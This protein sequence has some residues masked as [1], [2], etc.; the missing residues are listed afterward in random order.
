MLFL[1][2]NVF[3]LDAF[4]NQLQTNSIDTEPRHT[5]EESLNAVDEDSE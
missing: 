2:Q 3:Y 4:E 5:Q 1:F